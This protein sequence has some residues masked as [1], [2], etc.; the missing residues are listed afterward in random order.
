MTCAHA[1]RRPAFT[2]AVIRL[3]ARVP[4]PAI[5]FSARHAVGTDATSPNSSPWSPMTRKS[6]ITRAPSAIAHARP[7]STRPRS[8]TSS[9]ADASARGQAAGQPGLTGQLP[10]QRQPGMR[11]DT[12]TA[13]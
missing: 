2:A 12:L 1:C 13:A 10:Q 5:S 9:R 8:C 11:H 4:A 3:S 7:A 6:E